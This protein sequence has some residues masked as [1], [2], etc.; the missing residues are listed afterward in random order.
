[1]WETVVFFWGLLPQFAIPALPHPENHPGC[2]FIHPLPTLMLQNKVFLTRVPFSWGPEVRQVCN[3]TKTLVSLLMRWLLE[4]LYNRLKVKVKVAQSCLTPCNP[5]DYTVHGILQARILEWVAFPFSRESSQPKDWTQMS[6]SEL[7]ELVMDREAWRA[8]IHGVAKSRTQLSD[9]SD[10][11]FCIA[12][13]F[14]TSWAT[15]EAH[16]IRIYED[17]MA[18]NERKSFMACQTLYK[19]AMITFCP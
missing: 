14:F 4:F 3:G 2:L 6:L 18:Y 9:W 10:L 7:R 13:R 11:I 8:A 5:M 1:M 17:Q 16:N 15:R 19:V 12:S